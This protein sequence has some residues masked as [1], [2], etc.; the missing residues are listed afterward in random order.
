MSVPLKYLTVNALTGK[1]TATVIFVHGLGDS[2]HGWEPVAQM[3]NKDPELNHVKWIL[4]HAPSKPVTANFGM[5]MPSW[6]DIK[7][8]GFKAEEDEKGMLESSRQLNELITAEIDG[9]LDANRIVLGGFS[10]GGAMSLLTGLTS[11]RK[12]AG[13][14]VLSGFL[15]LRHKFKAM[16][17]DH[18]RS[19]PI[20]WGHGSVDPLVSYEM[21]EKSVAFLSK[22]CRVKELGETDKAVV[23]LRCKIYQG[24]E[25]SSCPE[26]M[27]DL[28]SWLKSI[29]PREARLDTLL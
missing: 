14:A 20:F 10:Q 8:F 6:F 22:E 1:H 5:A 26:E 18:A 28:R 16:L 12:L 23:G 9:G 15:P 25:H 13:L 17:S 2:G 29:I 27:D 4:P 24:M 21:C 3:F 11:E 7:S 19:T